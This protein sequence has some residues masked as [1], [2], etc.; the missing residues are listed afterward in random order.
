MS[1]P[2]SEGENFLGPVY[3]T[4]NAARMVERFGIRETDRVLDVGGGFYPFKRADVI[5]DL[6][7]SDTTNRNGAQMLFTEGKR[8]V[9]CP[10]E[11]LPFRDKEFDFV[12]CSHVLEH[13]VDPAA[14]CGEIQ[15]VGKRGYIEVPHKF[16]EYLTGNP[17]HRWLVT[18]K[19]GGLRFEAKNFIESPFQNVLH[20]H[21]VNDPEFQGV[22]AGSFRNLLNIQLAWTGSFPV[23]VV[24]TVERG[25]RFDYDD[26]RQAGLAHLLFAFNNLKWDANCEYAL[27]DAIE[28][29]RFLPDDA[30]AWHVLGIYYL[31]LLMLREGRDCLVR[32]RELRSGDATIEHNL[33]LAERFLA[34][35]R[36]DLRQVALP[37]IRRAID[38]AKPR[39]SLASA[40]SPLVSILYRAP[41]TADAIREGF[42]SIAAQRYPNRETIIVSEAPDDARRA[43]A[44]LST[45]MS[46]RY[47]A[48]PRGSSPGVAFNSALRDAKGE[49]V[50]YLD[51]DQLYQVYHL[52][53]LVG[54]LNASGESVA[55]SDALRVGFSESAGSPRRYAWDSQVV[56]STEFDPR[57]LEGRPSAAVPI[58]AIVHRRS[59][60]DAVGG[61]DPVMR[62]LL[63]RDLLT[64]LSR[65]FRI[66]HVRE[67]TLE[68]RVPSAGAA[69]SADPGA[70]P[71]EG[72]RLL[73]RYSHFEPLE[74]M[75]KVV[76]LYN[77]NEYLRHELE[78]TKSGSSAK[79]P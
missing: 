43:L 53:R 14:A 62:D 9:E 25:E 75:R 31:R 16:S 24:R 33:A 46:V 51:P 63:G 66:H 5:T 13:T 65:G 76:E 21:I 56:L 39:A 2:S 64:R 27:C 10:A 37:K 15:R 61:L 45:E 28:A 38:G 19:D 22:A 17:T 67:I 8:Y 60:A 40:A 6:S 72:Q 47:V 52:P 26:P 42:S 77:M 69:T 50:A 20:S 30:D 35:H 54:F 12:F 4:A 18:P 74:L 44:G 49:I 79:T 71:A 7:F 73:D 68:W 41:A 57:D 59:C 29:T 1:H 36:C 55:Y 70:V 34:E 11:T 32:A 23:E 3:P 58:G 78:R 48:T